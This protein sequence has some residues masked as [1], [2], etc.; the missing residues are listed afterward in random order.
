MSDTHLRNEASRNVFQSIEDLT[1]HCSR[2]KQGWFKCQAFSG[3]APRLPMK[4]RR[5][6]CNAAITAANTERDD[7]QKQT[8]KVWVV[9]ALYACGLRSDGDQLVEQLIESSHK[10]VPS[11][12]QGYMLELL[13]ENCRPDNDMMRK[14]I[15]TMLMELLESK[16]GWRVE[17]A[18]IHKAT[19][20]RST[21]YDG[22][23]NDLLSRCSNQRLIRRV[24]RDRERHSS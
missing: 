7:Y 2:I 22:F 13:F 20:F 23:V 24:I 11:N 16:G 19:C 6:A 12:S 14:R 5:K 21:E 17:R 18:I 4:D 10:I 15:L 3:A 1:K 9:N 8:A